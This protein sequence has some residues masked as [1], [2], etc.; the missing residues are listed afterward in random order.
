MREWWEERTIG[1]KVLVVIGFI[2]FGAGVALLFGF[3]V[4]W[5]WNWLMPDIFGLKRISYWQA[6]GLVVLSW[7]LFKN[8]DSSDS[9]GS[10]RKRKKKLREYMDEETDVEAETADNTADTSGAAETAA[11]EP[12][13]TGEER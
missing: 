10:E 1:Q 6:W 2:L 3:V 4:M 8:F 5:L 9:G 7:I 11:P 13:T 12:D